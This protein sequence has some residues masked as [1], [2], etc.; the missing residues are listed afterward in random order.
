[1]KH[2]AVALLLALATPCLH[3]H[4]S[5]PHAPHAPHAPPVR[6]SLSAYLRDAAGQE[7]TARCPVERLAGL[8]ELPAPVVT[9]CLG[10]ALVSSGTNA[11]VDEAVRDGCRGAIG[12][13]VTGLAGQSPRESPVNA[14]RPV[15]LCLEAPPH[16]PHQSPPKQRLQSPR[17]LVCFGEFIRGLIQFL[18]TQVNTTAVCDGSLWNRCHCGL[19][20][21]LGERLDCVFGTQLGETDGEFVV[22]PSTLDE[23]K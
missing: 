19:H 12:E 4:D 7:A 20:G 3:A 14:P 18:P 17:L 6:D 9:Y 22:R 15:A 8:L 1:M 13:A 21:T 16:P 23:M 5:P 11:S 2:V 10:L